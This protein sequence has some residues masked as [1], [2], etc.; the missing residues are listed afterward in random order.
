MVAGIAYGIILGN[1]TAAPFII[2]RRCV[3]AT[4][5]DEPIPILLTTTGLLLYA[6]AYVCAAV[7]LAMV[8]AATAAAA[9]TAAAAA[10]T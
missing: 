6:A 8:C 9:C 7:I 5:I 10:I 2:N 1:G 3:L 4:L